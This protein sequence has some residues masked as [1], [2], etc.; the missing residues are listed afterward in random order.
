MS[1]LIPNKTIQAILVLGVACIAILGGIWLG[2]STF[3]AN[4]QHVQDAAKSQPL[5]DSAASVIFSSTIATS[6]SADTAITK[7]NSATALSTASTPTVTLNGA[8]FDVRIANTEA[9]RERGLSG[10]SPLSTYQGMLFIFPTSDEY[11]FWMKDM[12]FALDM[13]WA[14]EDGRIV[15]IKEHATP[16]SFPAVF[17]PTA[18]ARVVLEVNSGTVA[19]LKLKTGD[20]LI[21][22]KNL[23][24]SVS[25]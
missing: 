20:R 9:L 22:D 21:F 25:N 7:A 18:P 8:V 5:S 14:D 16:E 10:S 1:A 6:S 2:T 12:T 23:L 17:T 4:Q 24:K 13:I 15:Y 3:V 11:R 19:N